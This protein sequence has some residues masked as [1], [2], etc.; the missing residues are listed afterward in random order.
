MKNFYVQLTSIE[1]VKQFNAAACDTAFD[2]DIVSG[3]YVIDAKSIMGLFS[4][5]LARPIRVDARG[6]DAGAEGFYRKVESLVVEG[7]PEK[8]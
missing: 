2:V 8:K 4:L 1:D 5:D 3:R 6:D 7:P